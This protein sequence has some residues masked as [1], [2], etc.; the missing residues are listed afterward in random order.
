MT[1]DKTLEAIETLP[2]D[3]VLTWKSRFNPD[4]GKLNSD[5]LK[6]L[7]DELKHLREF[8]GDAMMIQMKGDVVLEVDT[9]EHGDGKWHVCDDWGYIMPP[10]Y[11]SPID[12]WQKMKGDLQ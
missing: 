5:D 8:V 6:H 12:A 11:D 9:D 10:G 4:C 3:D 1:T 2:D 7:A